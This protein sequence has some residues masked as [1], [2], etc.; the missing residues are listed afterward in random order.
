M[1][2]SKRINVKVNKEYSDKE[3]SMLVLLV[4]LSGQMILGNLYAP[5]LLE[6]SGKILL[7]FGELPIILGGNF[8]QH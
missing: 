6:N 4:T 3:R 1:L 5:I 8:N 2:F 7:D